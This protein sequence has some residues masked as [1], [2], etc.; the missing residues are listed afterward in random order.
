[1]GT[2]ATICHDLTAAVGHDLPRSHCCSRPFL[3]G[4]GL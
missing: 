2:A 4:L 3:A 1:M